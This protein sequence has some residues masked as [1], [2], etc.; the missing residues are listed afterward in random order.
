MDFTNNKLDLFTTDFD[1]FN[2]N[3]KYLTHKIIIIDNLID[4]GKKSNWAAFE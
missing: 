2:G 4:G 3:Y 1:P